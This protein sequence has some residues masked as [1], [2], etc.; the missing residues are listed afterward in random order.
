MRNG[1]NQNARIQNKR[2]LSDDLARLTSK[3]F[4]IGVRPA[5]LDRRL[6]ELSA[7]TPWLAVYLLLINKDMGHLWNQ[8]V[9]AKYQH[10]RQW[11]FP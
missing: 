7:G 5:A 4:L 8:A 11:F 10:R 9:S 3:G 2:Q 6:C 1:R